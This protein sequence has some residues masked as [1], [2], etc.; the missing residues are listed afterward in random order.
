[1]QYSFNYKSLHIVSFSS[2]G[3][4]EGSDDEILTSLNWL[5]KDL[6]EANRNRKERP[7]IIVEGHRPLYCT[8]YSDVNDTSCLTD[9]QTLRDGKLNPTTG[10]RSH[11]VEAIL[12]KYKVDIYLCGHRHN[13]ERTY[14]VLKGQVTSKSYH[15]APSPFQ[16]LV[17]NSGNYELTIPF[18]STGPFPDWSASRY[19]GYGYSTVKA[20][21]HSLELTHWGVSNNGTNDHVVDHVIVTKD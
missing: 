14:P 20:T 11:G 10:T 9:T 12:D 5:E 16:Y 13:F 1:M 6:E 21:K 15:N 2:E 3:A 17:G 8:S 18:N 19:S 4:F 7:W